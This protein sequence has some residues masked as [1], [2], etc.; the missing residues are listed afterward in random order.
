M[1]V[2]FAFAVSV[3]VMGILGLVLFST[4]SWG[5]ESSRYAD[6]NDRDCEIGRER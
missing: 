4:Y 3:I 6:E 2:V 5:T 1:E